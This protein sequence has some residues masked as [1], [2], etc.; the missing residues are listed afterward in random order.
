VYIPEFTTPEAGRQLVEKYRLD[1]E[2]AEKAIHLAE[3]AYGRLC[4]ARFE[5]LAAAVEEAVRAEL[6]PKLPE[7]TEVEVFDSY[8]GDESWH[9]PLAVSIEHP[10][11]LGVDG[12]ALCDAGVGTVEEQVA[13]LL[14]GLREGLRIWLRE[15]A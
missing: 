6:L 1:R 10:D 12:Y 13:Y 11:I 14:E 3:R 7:G 2:H 15:E 9:A 5:E 4:L 8:N